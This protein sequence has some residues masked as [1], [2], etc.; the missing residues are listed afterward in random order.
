M[1]SGRG[2]AS[3]RQPDR[4]HRQRFGHL[5]AGHPGVREGDLSRRE[6]RG[7]ADGHQLPQRSE[8]H[9]RR[10]R[11]TIWGGG[12]AKAAP[13]YLK[14]GGGSLD[15][16]DI[17]ETSGYFRDEIYFSID[18][19]L[20][21]FL[22]FDFDV[23]YS[24]LNFQ[25]DLAGNPLPAGDCF[26]EFGLELWY[27]SADGPLLLDDYRM[28]LASNGTVA[29]APVVFSDVV[30]LSTRGAGDYYL[31]N[32]RYFPLT[33]TMWTEAWKGNAG[34]ILERQYIRPPF[35][36]V[37][38]YVYGEMGPTGYP[39]RLLDD[40][41]FTLYSTTIPEPASMVLIGLGIV[42]LWAGRRRR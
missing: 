20:F 34:G 15:P 16:N 33:V 14:T 8:R 22:E 28:S 25:K 23:M 2:L 32:G 1:R 27:Q 31:A 11:G 10:L 41:E 7:V 39:T 4:H 6:Y 21:G 30:T 42:G 26:A 36:D 17:V 37:R 13:S 38:A 40:D 19:G 29:T 24:L 9:R 35:D 18:S 5:L 12:F 3:I